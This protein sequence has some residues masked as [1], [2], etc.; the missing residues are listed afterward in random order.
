[1]RHC[2]CKSSTFIQLYKPFPKVFSKYFLTNWFFDIYKK[3]FLW[4]CDF[5]VCIFGDLDSFERFWDWLGVAVPSKGRR[6]A[7]ID[8]AKSPM[9]PDYI[10][11]L[12]E[13]PLPF[14]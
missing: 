1:M 6:P 11:E 5:S 8:L 10:L 4:I 9:E 13:K 3:P 7:A 12:P 2:G 14:R